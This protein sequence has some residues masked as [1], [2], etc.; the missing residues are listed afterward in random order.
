MGYMVAAWFHDQPLDLP[1]LAVSGT[2]GQAPAYVYL[3]RWDGV[4]GDLLRGFRF[5]R[6]AGNVH[7]RVPRPPWHLRSCVAWVPGGVEVR[8]G[9]GLLGAPERLELG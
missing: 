4:D 1:Y 2:D 6:P 8:H 3:A 5:A 7:P 9:L